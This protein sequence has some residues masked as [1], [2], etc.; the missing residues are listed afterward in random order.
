VGYV[1]QDISRGTYDREVIM[2]VRL[3]VGSPLNKYYSNRRLFADR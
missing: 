1:A 3:P 2:L